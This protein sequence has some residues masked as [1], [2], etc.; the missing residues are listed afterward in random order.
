MKKGYH[1]YVPLIKDI[2]EDKKVAESKDLN[3]ERYVTTTGGITH[4]VT[5]A[6][7]M[8]VAGTDV[9]QFGHKFPPIYNS[10]SINSPFK[11][12]TKDYIKYN[13]RL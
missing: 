2:D 5:N 8:V 1:D 13:G 9:L 7:G 6:K 11:M 4:M 3:K 12:S 10:S